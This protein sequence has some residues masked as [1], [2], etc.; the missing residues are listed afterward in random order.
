MSELTN[1][2]K[3][4]LLDIAEEQLWQGII[5]DEVEFDNDEYTE[6]YKNLIEGEETDP[7]TYF[8]DNSYNIIEE[9][10]DQIEQDFFTDIEIGATALGELKLADRGKL[11]EDELSYETIE[12]LNSIVG[13]FQ[14]I[15]LNRKI[16][17]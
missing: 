12:T 11:T 17:K 9:L 3:Q 13:K 7:F 10:K 8:K 5:I 15:D 14:Y 6:F 2:Q 4:E 16:F 1:K